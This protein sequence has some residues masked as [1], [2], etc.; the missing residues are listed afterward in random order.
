[1]CVCAGLGLIHCGMER[2]GCVE[3]SGHLSGVED[4]ET[5][6]GVLRSQAAQGTCSI[7]LV[8]IIISTL[9]LFKYS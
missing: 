4:R 7:C 3:L 6:V 5:R 9:A 8:A 2:W 1:M